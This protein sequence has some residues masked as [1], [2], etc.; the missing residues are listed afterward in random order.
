MGN[1]Q[2]IKPVL[3]P[4]PP[5]Y[6]DTPTP[7]KL[8]LLLNFNSHYL[9]HK[10]SPYTDYDNGLS[11]FNF[12][13]KDPLIW[14]YPDEGKKGLFGLR[15]YE[16]QFLPFASA[17]IDVIR[18]TKFMASGRGLLFSAK[19]F[20]LQTGNAFNETRIYNPLSPIVAA[21]RIIHPIRHIEPNLGSLLGSLFGVAPKVTRPPGT[22]PDAL[23]VGGQN[24][25]KGLLRSGT[26]EPAKS[27]LESKWSSPASSP[28][29]FFKGIL[30]S[31][32]AQFS[33]LPTDQEYK[34][35]ADE[36][37]YGLMLGSDKLSYENQYGVK[38]NLT[39]DWFAGNTGKGT[40]RPLSQTP[41]LN[42]DK[43]KAKN[44]I[45]I[46]TPQVNI[47]SKLDK[48]VKYGSFIGLDAIHSINLGD[49]DS[50]GMMVKYSY[51][52]DQSDDSTYK[53]P[54]KRETKKSVD[55]YNKLLKKTLENIKKSGIYKIDVPLD[56]VI[57]SSPNP[58]KNGYD[59]LISAKNGNNTNPLNYNLGVLVDYR[60]AGT[61][62]IEGSITDNAKD[63]SYKTAGTGQFDAINTLTVLDKDKTIEDTLIPGWTKWEPYEDD[64]IAFY[65][66]D[67]VN[68]KYIPF[69]ATV[70]GINESGTAT[71]DEL[72]FI[73]RS[74]RLYSYGGFN[75]AL[76]FNFVVVINSVVELGPTWQRIAYLMSVIKPS[77]YTKKEIN[78]DGALTNVNYNRFLVPPMMT[79]TIGDLYKDQ[80]VVINTV[81]MTIPENAVWETL[82]EENSNAEWNYLANYI[83]SNKIPWGGKGFGQFPR[84][85]EISVTCALLEKERPLIG[86]S[87]FGHAIRSTDG[88][89]DYASVMSKNI[90]ADLSV[91]EK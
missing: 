56:A 28:T 63:K 89:L 11:L 20:L 15:K 39:Q 18:I 76:S 83:K 30:N 84:E 10:F 60:N 46:G 71:W 61:K 9:Y 75:R 74:D 33:F 50:S 6:P 43:Y 67:L 44:I 2:D 29:G 35:R 66:K 27:L 41:I 26:A 70:K 23:R 69:R 65:F 16:S 57:F 49:Y 77:N 25:A 72:S 36:G 22:V 14:A 52:A 80:P 48:P 31:F 85:V 32:K 59:R 87:Q 51:Y 7:G 40:I 47:D 90:R 54:T 81:G 58:T 13:A 78:V 45:G 88:T 38:V 24:D 21:A 91:G 79:V 3:V 82:N 8:E 73:G 17:P 1:H 53:N 5:G 42:T 86:G 55:E 19:Q 68:N 64:L 37:A 34:A 62:V 12:G 4:V